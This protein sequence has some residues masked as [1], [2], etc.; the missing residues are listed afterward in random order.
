MEFKSVIAK[1][2]L[3][4]KYNNVCLLNKVVIYFYSINCDL[5]ISTLKTEEPISPSQNSSVFVKSKFCEFQNFQMSNSQNFQ[6]FKSPN[7]LW[8]PVLNS[9]VATAIMIT[10][11]LSIYK[12]ITFNVK[13]EW[14]FFVQSV[15]WVLKECV[16]Q[17]YTVCAVLWNTCK[18]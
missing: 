4:Q 17:W 8:I 3:Y 1:N 5:L 11:M 7:F 15:S 18:L 12:R 16:V 14:T 9:G 13:T 2:N 10:D 6:I